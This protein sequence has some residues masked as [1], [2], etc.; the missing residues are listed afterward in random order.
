MSRPLQTLPP[1]SAS[2]TSELVSTL[3][4]KLTRAERQAQREAAKVWRRPE[5]PQPFLLQLWV[6]AH[7]HGLPEYLEHFPEQFQRLDR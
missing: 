7:S 2:D 3:F 1:I 4:T 5:P 6:T